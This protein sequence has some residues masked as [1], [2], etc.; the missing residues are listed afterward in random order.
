[1]L[2]RSAK[3]P[4]KTLVGL[5]SVKG[6]A[7]YAADKYGK[8]L[9]SALNEEIAEEF[10]DI[11]QVDIDPGIIKICC[12]FEDGKSID[13]VALIMKTDKGSIA[14][15][16]Q[17][18]IMSGQVNL[19]WHLFVSEKDY[20][21]IKQTIYKKPHITLKSLRQ[22]ITSDIDYGILRIVSAIARSNT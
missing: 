3:N 2:F 18:S 10:D 1:M 4:P 22:T 13:D 14:R 11:P 8:L 12:L 20:N 7:K 5:Y 16:V 6:V 19:D 17:S 21:K 15:M 9:L